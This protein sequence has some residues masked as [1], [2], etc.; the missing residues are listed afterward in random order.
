MLTTL[1]KTVYDIRSSY[2]YLY[3]IDTTYGGR[4]KHI[5]GLGRRFTVLCLYIVYVI[6][7]MRELLLCKEAS[8][9]CQYWL[10]F[11]LR[12]SSS[13]RVETTYFL[14]FH[15]MKETAPVTETPC[16]V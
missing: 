4:T 6:L 5:D 9:Y 16:F 3:I 10:G 8:Y 13:G 7:Q 14:P 11:G 1:A 2:M 15:L 12:P